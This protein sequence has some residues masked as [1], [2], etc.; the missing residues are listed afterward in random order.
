MTNLVTLLRDGRKGAAWSKYCGFI[1]LSLAQFMEVQERLLAEQLQL[2]SGSLLGRKLLRNCTKV[3][4]ANFRQKVPLTS[5][6]DYLPYLA[7]KREDVLPAAPQMW[8]C[9]SGKA[10]AYDRKWAPYTHA[11]VE[12]NAKNFLAAIIFSVC[13]KRNEFILR[14]GYKFLYAMAPPPYLTGMVPHGLK[15][16][17]PFEYLPP[18]AQAEEMSFE[19]QNQ[20]GFRLGMIEGIDLFFGLS[21]IL[22]RIGERFAE[23]GGRRLDF[24]SLGLGGSLRLATGWIKSRWHRR[25][26]LPRDVWNLKGIICAG[27]DT[28]FYKECIEYYWGR[29]PLEIYGGTE[30]GIAATQTWDYDGMV[31]FPDANFWEFIPEEEHRK[32]MVDGSYQPKTVLLPE[33]EPGRRYELVITNFRGG[34]FVRY[35]L[36]DMIKVISRSNDKLEID[37]PQI[38]YEDR[39]EDFIDLA[40][41][42]R[43]T[44]R[45]IWEALR[46][47]GIDHSHWL[48]KKGTDNSGRPTLE[49]WLELS[50]E[51]LERKSHTIYDA[52]KQLDS[53]YRDLENFM[54]YQPLQL[55]PFPPGAWNRLAKQLM[56]TRLNPP[57]E[58]LDKLQA[59]N[60]P[61]D[62][63]NAL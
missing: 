27:T 45:T 19:E 53:D 51:N 54:G 48:A 12:A 62:S 61:A 56:E 49:I 41:F 55:I 26:L 60:L 50:K 44:E 24:N 23:R 39:V 14:E 3:A 47:A 10:G 28:T 31:L 52:L 11:W 59:H 17:F 33:L 35:R 38:V 25:P 18:L 32:S 5:Y 7:E 21:S 58:L 43:I 2:L 40:S 20:E 6:E 4:V 34:I 13:N 57:A 36:G 1:D 37:L 63:T 29:K 15:H 8:V 16:E 9:T 22:T 30:V 46:L 42:T